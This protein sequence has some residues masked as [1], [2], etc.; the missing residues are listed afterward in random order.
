MIGAI[1]SA[2]IIGA[3]IGAL[4]RL[5]VPGKQN[6]SIGLTILVGIVAALIGTLIAQA[7]GWADTRG[8]DWIE[9]L[10]QLLLAIVGVLIVT[11]LGMG[12][13]GGRSTRGTRGTP[14]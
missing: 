12:R 11:R 5:I 4:A 1:V 14:T 13:R 8:I 3:I 2:I 7:V 9:H 10:L 6:M